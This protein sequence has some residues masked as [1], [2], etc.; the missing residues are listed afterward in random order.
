VER[1]LDHAI[2]DLRT[3]VGFPTVAADES[4]QMDDCI[5]FL[6]QNIQALDGQV[7]ILTLPSARPLL[8]A[9]IPG[10]RERSLMFYQHYD[11]QP[12]GPRQLWSSDPFS[13]TERGSQ[14]FGRG[15]ADNKGNLA[16]RLAAIRVLQ[17]TEEGLPLTL[18][19]LVEGEEEIGS[20]NLPHYLDRYDDLL[21][22]DGCL[23]E[24]GYRDSAGRPVI[25]LGIKGICKLNL[26]VHGPKRDLHGKFAPLASNPAQELV[27]ALNTI[28][29]QD[30]TVRIPGYYDPIRL[31]DSQET[32]WLDA[33]APTVESLR[34]ELGL[35]RLPTSDGREAL[36]RLLF[37]SVCNISGLVAGSVGH[38]ARSIVPSSAEAMVSFR[39][40][41]DQKPEEVFEQVKKHLREKRLEN[42]DVRYI[43]G[44][45]PARTPADHPLVDS[46]IKAVRAVYD[47]EPAVWPMTPGAGPMSMVC[48]SRGMAAVAMGVGHAG[49]NTHAPDENIRRNDYRLGIEAVAD[50]MRRF[51]TV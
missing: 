29:E 11:V 19:F 50:F 16:A 37:F 28:A 20:P 33:A 17:Q 49:S 41:P 43:N 46:A 35:D 4:Y 12:S 13:L 42:V 22:A 44:V 6:A 48:H 3:L 30:G 38:E 7:Q 45:R 24:G 31:P 18:R 47:A 25:S 40:A 34:R 8:Y 36:E 23:W 9:E 14:I 51:A 32:A 26:R 21:Q 10:R 15:V 39:L 2:E 1:Q 27:V 5:G